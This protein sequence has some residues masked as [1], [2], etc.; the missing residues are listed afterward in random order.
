MERL[1]NATRVLTHWKPNHKP[2]YEQ[3][4]AELTA[5]RKE[6]VETVRQLLWRACTEG[7]GQIFGTTQKRVAGKVADALLNEEGSD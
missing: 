4:V 1:E 6:V 5:A 2:H 7:R 3:A